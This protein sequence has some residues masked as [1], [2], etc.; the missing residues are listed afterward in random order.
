[1]HPA[2]RDTR[3]IACLIA[4]IG[5][6]AAYTALSITG[7]SADGD[8]ALAVATSALAFIIGFASDPKA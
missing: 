7:H 2:L 4:I 3:G 1:M 8:K 6:L 5:G